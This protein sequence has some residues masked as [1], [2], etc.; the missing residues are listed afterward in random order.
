MVSHCLE[1]CPAEYANEDSVGDADS[2][3][4]STA[5]R[6]TGRSYRPGSREGRGHQDE[7]GRRSTQ[8]RVHWTGK[9][10]RETEHDLQRCCG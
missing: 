5:D 8:L 10:A 7:G 2:K 6:F 1:Q 3:Y 4:R 9:K